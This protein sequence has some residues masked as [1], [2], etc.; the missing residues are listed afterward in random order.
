MKLHF[1]AINYTARSADGKQKGLP[2]VQI[3]NPVRV[4]CVLVCLIKGNADESNSP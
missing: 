2:E 1:K 3:I 4:S